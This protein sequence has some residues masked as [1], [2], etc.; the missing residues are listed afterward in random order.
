MTG[1]SDFK[2]KSQCISPGCA[3]TAIVILKC[4]DL[5]RQLCGRCAD[6]HTPLGWTFVDW[7][8][9]KD[10]YEADQERVKRSNARQRR[11]R[12]Y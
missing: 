11:V 9:W 5:R 7:T 6:N 1:Y 10:D 12:T 8:P 3:Q 2:L 4:D